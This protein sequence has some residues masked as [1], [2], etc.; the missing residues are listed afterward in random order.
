MRARA[1]AVVWGL[2]ALS[3]SGCLSPV[4]QETD[5]IV[6]HSASVPID[7]LPTAPPPLEQSPPPGVKPAAFVGGSDGGIQPVGGVQPLEGGQPKLTLSGRLQLPQNLPGAEAPKLKIPKDFTK[8]P[9]AEQDKI[10]AQ[11]FP[12]MLPVGPDPAP[13][14][15]PHGVPLTLADLQR[16]ARE[17][18][19]Q[20]REA[21]G[22][23]AAAEGAAWEAGMYP[24]PVI[25]LGTNSIGPNGG[26]L[27][28]PS[29]SQ[30]IK[31]GGKLK[32]A[33]DM[34]LMDLANAKLAYRRAETDLMASVRSNYYGVLV[35]LASIK[36]S[37]ALVEL[38]DAVLDVQLLQMKVGEVAPYEP[39][40]MS[41]FASQARAALVTAR[42]SYLLAWK[43]LASAMGLPAMPA[44]EV[45]GS[46]MERLPRF[47]YERCLTHILA[48]HTDALTALN[49][50]QKMRY[51]LRLNEVTPLPDLTLGATLMYDA[52]PPGPPRW[53]T[54]FTGSAPVPVWDRNQ[55]GIKQAQGQLAQAIEEPHRVRADLTARVSDAFRRFEENRVL[56]EMYVKQMLPQ[57]ANAFRAAVLRHD[58]GD[59]GGLGY[60]DLIAA[61]QNLVT[62]I[63]AYLGTLGAYWQAVSDIASLLQTDNVYQMADEVENCPLP[64]LGELLKLP[65]CHPCSSLPQAALKGISPLLSPPGQETSPPILGVERGTS[66]PAKIPEAPQQSRYLPEPESIAPAG[67]TIVPARLLPP[68]SG[69]PAVV[70]GRDGASGQQPPTLAG[71]AVLLQPR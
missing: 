56:L 46:I 8:L 57:Q 42:N 16:L 24:N 26:P 21:A 27:M 31:T 41:V 54:F 39:L 60:Y 53:V 64:D 65:C 7:W 14:P 59:V 6:C 9:R 52:T 33:Q 11:Y 35:A 67:P 25:G 36:A 62:L 48:K 1:I 38:S 66:P 29:L 22:V 20:L 15:G 49:G 4:Q 34:G 5:A 40:Q 69:G 55:G 2:A 3:L 71:E 37:R 58:I 43:Q 18:S 63:P 10:T 17:N 19:P 23:I 30:T 68:L 61:E 50:I 44:T 13:Q 32:L 12:K 45:A 51:N 28:G 47:S 70:P